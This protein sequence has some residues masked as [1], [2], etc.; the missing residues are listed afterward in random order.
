[1]HFECEY[2]DETNGMTH[3]SAISRERWLNEITERTG[4]LSDLPWKNIP[5]L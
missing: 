4:M 2:P 1:M 3:V 5:P